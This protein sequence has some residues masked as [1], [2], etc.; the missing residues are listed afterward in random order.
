[1][2]NV[3]SSAVFTSRLRICP[4]TNRTIVLSYATITNNDRAGKFAISDHSP[5]QGLH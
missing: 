1:M 4:Q 2:F 3:N 5:V